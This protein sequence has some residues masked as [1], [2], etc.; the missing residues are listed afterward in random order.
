ML[1]IICC[2]VEMFADKQIIS[3]YERGEET[4]LDEVSF[5]LAGAMIAQYCHNYETNK[6]HLYG[7]EDYIESLIDDIRTTDMF[8]YRNDAK[9]F[10]IEVN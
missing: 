2:R 3:L 1:P 9:I 5:E 8:M 7:Q 6:I 4:K 10:D